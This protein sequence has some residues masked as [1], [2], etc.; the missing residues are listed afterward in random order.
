M[1]KITSC[2]F[3]LSVMSDNYKNMIL[4]ALAKV[5][6]TAVTSTTDLLATTYTG[7]STDVLAA[8]QSIF[9]VVNDNET[10]ITMEATLSPV[11]ITREMTV[12]DSVPVVKNFIAHGK[13]ALYQLGVLNYQNHIDNINRFAKSCKLYDKPALHG[14]EFHGDINKIFDFLTI[15]YELIEVRIDDFVIQISLSVNSPSLL[16]QEA[17]NSVCSDQGEHTNRL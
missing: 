14:C 17:M 6:T 2:R 11:N 16:K 4:D 8:L 10:H 9:T 15:V 3:S 13:I 1:E 7:D 5:D 12:T